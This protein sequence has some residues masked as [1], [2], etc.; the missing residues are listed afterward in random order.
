MRTHRMV[1]AA[2]VALGGVALAACGGG[3]SYSGSSHTQAVPVAAAMSTAVQSRDT[4]LG[5]VLVSP[6]GH[7]LYALT[8]DTKGKS[9][10]T[11]ACAQVWPP[12]AVGNGWTAGTGLNRS[13][14]STLVRSDGTRQLVAGQWPLYTFSGDS[15]PGDVNGE[16]SGGVWFAVGVDGKLVKTAPATATAI[17]SAGY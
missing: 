11:G 4:S 13:L 14:F 16:G 12:L 1:A 10:C 6:S 8:T 9:T 3:S 15:K 7:T 2:V 17:A 5:T